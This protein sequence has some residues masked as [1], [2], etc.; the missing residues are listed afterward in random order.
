MIDFEKLIKEEEEK[1]KAKNKIPLQK[2]KL[3]TVSIED[4]VQFAQAQVITEHGGVGINDV[5]RC[6]GLTFEI[7][8]MTEEGKCNK[9]HPPE[10]QSMDDEDGCG[11]TGGSCICGKPYGHEDEHECK[12]CGEEW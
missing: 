6:H 4:M 1:E 11:E 9:I 12:L 10:P 5:K 8:D 3:V 7:P 2:V